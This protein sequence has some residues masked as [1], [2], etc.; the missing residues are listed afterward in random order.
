MI[1]DFHRQRMTSSH[2]VLAV[3]GA[4]VWGLDSILMIIVGKTKIAKTQARLEGAH[5]HFLMVRLVCRHEGQCLWVG[6]RPALAL[7]CDSFY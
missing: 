2:H 4:S 3:K 7:G 6:L 1:H 5:K